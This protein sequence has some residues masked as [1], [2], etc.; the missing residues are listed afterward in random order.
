MFLVGNAAGE[1]HPILGEGISMALH[2]ARLLAEHLRERSVL[3]A[4]SLGQAQARYARA[5]RSR[6]AGRIHLSRLVVALAMR[7]GL[8]PALLPLLQRW[9]GLLSLLARAGGKTQFA[10]AAPAGWARRSG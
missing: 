6:L 1:A 4:D 8:A 2:G 10:V 7:P 3:D 5:W 9:P